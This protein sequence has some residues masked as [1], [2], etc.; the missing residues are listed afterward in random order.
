MLHPGPGSRVE[1]LRVWELEALGLLAGELGFRSF[2]QEP[3]YRQELR[4]QNY[5]FVC[6][7]VSER[8]G[9]MVQGSGFRVHSGFMV[10]GSGFRVQGVGF[11]VQGS[12]FRVQ[13]SGF[14][15]QGSGYRV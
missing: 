1:G 5:V 12:G 10:H 13:G 15:V 7:C 3:R 9:F 4:R 14:R 8:A 11:R 2:I 6:V